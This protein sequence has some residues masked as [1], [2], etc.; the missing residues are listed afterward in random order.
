MSTRVLIWGSLAGW[1]LIQGC[2]RDAVS[3]VPT[4]VSPVV[5][6]PTASA[7]PPP[8]GILFRDRTE[9][10]RL[11][12][13]Y[14]NDEAHSNF[15]ILE[16]MGGGVAVFDFDL[17]GRLDLFLPGGGTFGDRQTAGLPSALFRNIADWEFLDVTSPSEAGRATQLDHGH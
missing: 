15:A 9:Q 8:T 11:R 17:D 5:P 7:N 12:F 10:S 13:T 6:Q 16:S 4:T 14:R 3:P 2:Q 1:L